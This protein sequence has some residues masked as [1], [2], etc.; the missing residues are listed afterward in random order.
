MNAL[1]LHVSTAPVLIMSTSTHAGVSLGIQVLIVKQ[2]F[3]KN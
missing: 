2:V 3:K 1:V